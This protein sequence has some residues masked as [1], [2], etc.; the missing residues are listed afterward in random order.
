MRR[1]AFLILIAAVA[2]GGIVYTVHHSQSVSNAAVTALLPRS[3]I[4]FV[5]LPDFNRTRD[6]WH[7]TDIYKLSQEPATR[8]FL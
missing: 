6:D 4:A 8:D 1:F 5:H 7:Q 3:T 2:A